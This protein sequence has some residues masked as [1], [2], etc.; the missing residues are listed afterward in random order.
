MVS[1][2]AKQHFLKLHTSEQLATVKAGVDNT[3]TRTAMIYA[4]A[5]MA[6]MGCNAEQL[7][8]ARTFHRLLLNI[9]DP[10]P[11]PKGLPRIALEDVPTRPTMT[12]SAEKK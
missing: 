2:S 4:I 9:T 7:L 3:I 12:G 8:G 11:M 1:L 6:E 5:Q 10:E